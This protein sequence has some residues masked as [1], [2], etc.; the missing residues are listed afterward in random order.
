MI[1][2][3]NLLLLV[4]ALHYVLGA[5]SIVAQS[6]EPTTVEAK[7]EQQSQAL[8]NQPDEK[9]WL[10]RSTDNLTSLIGYGIILLASIVA[11]TQWRRDQ[12]WKRLE[13]LLVRVKAFNDTPGSMNAIMM[14]FSEDREV[15]LWDKEKPEDRYV[16]VSNKEVSRALIPTDMLPQPYDAKM[17]A[18]R[19]S[20]NDLLNRLSHIEAFLEAEL[21]DKKEV[22]Y[23]M[24]D[25]VLRFQRFSENDKLSRNLRIYIDWKRLERV[26]KLFERFD[27]PLRG[28]I[29]NEKDE[30]RGEIEKGEWN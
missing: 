16:R 14:L 29:N 3:W 8:A 26:Q 22:G 17:I 28:N 5:S 12:K 2:R 10:F 19:D 1:S 4:I 6:T 20:F 7:V 24:D 13:A 23:I 18:I 15:P 27:I 9:S 25:F 21:L 30:L 11:Y